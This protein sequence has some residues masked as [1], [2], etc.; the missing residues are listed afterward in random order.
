MRFRND[1]AHD[2]DLRANLVEVHPEAV[3]VGAL[4]SVFD[5]SC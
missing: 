3:L 4:R 5:A 2:P 1:R